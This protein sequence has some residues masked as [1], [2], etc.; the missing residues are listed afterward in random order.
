MG[1]SPYGRLMEKYYALELDYLD[2]KR[3]LDDMI[4][5]YNTE[6]DRNKDE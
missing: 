6:V 4:V 3:Q 2:L 5:A 1:S